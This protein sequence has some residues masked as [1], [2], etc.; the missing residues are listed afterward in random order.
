ME[1]PWLSHYEEG[2]P[3]E[4][5]IPDYPVTQNLINSAEKYPNNTATIFGNVVCDR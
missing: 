5:E 2:V 1:K 3:A 4:V